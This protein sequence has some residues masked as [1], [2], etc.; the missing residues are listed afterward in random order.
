MTYVVVFARVCLKVPTDAQC[1]HCL[2]SKYAT[3]MVAL[4]LLVIVFCTIVPNSHTDRQTYTC[5]SHL[6][7]VANIVL[8]E[9]Y[10]YQST[11]FNSIK[12]H[13]SSEECNRKTVTVSTNSLIYY[14]GHD[15]LTRN[16]R[17]TNIIFTLNK[18]IK[19]IFF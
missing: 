13:H 10:H 3:T 9:E 16:Y 7:L 4:T 15:P 6:K 11:E 5:T 19:A 8:S 1:L 18:L 17:F 2:Y 14:A 12:S